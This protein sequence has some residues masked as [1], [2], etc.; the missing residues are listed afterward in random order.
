MKLRMLLLI[1]FAMRWIACSAF[2]HPSSGIVV[3]DNGEVFFVHSGKGVGKIDVQGKLTYVHE[4]KGG[5][6]ICLD[7]EGS[8]SRTQPKFFERITPDGA[9]PAL[10]FADG[11]APVAVCRDGNLYFASNWRGGD[12]HPPGGLTVS[13]VSPDG[14]LAH[15]SPTLRETLAKLDEGVTGLAAGPDGLLYVASPS[16]LFQV[17]LDG[18]L[19][20]LVS[21]AVLQ[22]CDEDLPPNWRAPGFRGLTVETNGTVY[23]AAAGCRRVVKITNT[24]EAAAVLKSEKAWNPTDMALHA[25]E[26]YVLEWTHANS[27][28]D[29]GW[30]PRVRKLAPDGTISLLVEIRENVAGP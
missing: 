20:S 21:P 17:K 4:S 19:T 23:A 29:D 11:G 25:G 9:K 26:L 3:N 6:W 14:K 27:G 22:D 13:R 28:R 18:T 15:V 7:R 16:S 12:E 24:G 30:R 8:F 1:A 2:A 10:I 5:H